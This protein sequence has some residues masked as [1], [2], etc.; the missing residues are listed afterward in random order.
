MINKKEEFEVLNYYDYPRYLPSMDGLGY[1]INGQVDGDAGFEF[2]TFNDIRVINQKSEAFRNGTLEFAEDIK[3]DLYKELRIDVNNNNYF[4]RKMIEDIILDPN[5]E[6]ITKI[7]NIT[8]KDTM[9]NF[10][11]ILVKLTNDNEYDI[12]NRVREYID[13]REYELNNKITKSKLPI[14]KS[15]VYKP[16]KQEDIEIAV[17]EEKESKQKNKKTTTD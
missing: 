6:K 2:V 3:D 7:V 11:R 16:T 10:R 4:T 17:V 13:A 5:D 9:D 1:K 14:P 8:S 15:K 12:S